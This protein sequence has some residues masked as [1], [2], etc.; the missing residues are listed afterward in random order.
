[1]TAG[2]QLIPGYYVE[3]GGLMS[4]GSDVLDGFRQVGVMPVAFSRA[5]S[6]RICRLCSQPSSS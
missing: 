2:G 5:Q 1:M 6:L 4:Y 3:V